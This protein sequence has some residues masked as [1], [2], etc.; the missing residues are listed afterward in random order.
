MKKQKRSQ[1]ILILFVLLIVGFLCALPF[2]RETITTVLKTK[3]YDYLP[4][5]A[6]E[7]IEKVYEETGEIVPTEKNKKENEPYL[8]P[9]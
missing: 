2:R 4:R 9:K 7:Y 1:F 8:N 5:E 3:S 6:K